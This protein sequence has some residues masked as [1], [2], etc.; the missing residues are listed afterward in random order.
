M[1][2]S[3][4]VVLACQRRCPDREWVL[5][6]NEVQHS[7]HPILLSRHS[8]SRTEIVQ[9]MSQPRGRTAGLPPL[10][11]LPLLPLEGEDEGGR[12]DGGVC[13][14]GCCGGSGSKE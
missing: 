4:A 12:A 3:S 9:H 13:T 8:L 7:V 6:F 5:H 1:C 10:V 14:R 11:P 2:P